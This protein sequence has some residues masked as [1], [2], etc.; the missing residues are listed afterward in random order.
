MIL[1]FMQIYLQL[2]NTGINIE[3]GHV[4]NWCYKS[5]NGL[6]YDVTWFQTENPIKKR[7][8]LQCDHLEEN[9][10]KWAKN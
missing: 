7:G 9:M 4:Q 8:K 1:Y 3:C 6:N 2:L 5:A 10:L